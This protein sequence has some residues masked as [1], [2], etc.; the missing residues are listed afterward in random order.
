V[1]D[2]AIRIAHPRDAEAI[3]SI[4]APIVA[5][6]VVSFEERVP[7]LEDMRERIA[8]SHTWL[9]A[10]NEGNLVGYAYASRFHPRSAYRWSAEVSI[11]LASAARGRGLGRFLLDAVLHRLGAMGYVNAF[12]GIT[13][14]NDASIRLFESSGFTKIATW[15]DAGFKLGRWHDVGW[16]QLQLREPSI[17]PPQLG[18]FD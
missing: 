12:A 3:L 10:E 9:V 5:D 11:Y 2:A 14:P 8:A 4:Y 18:Q 13:L 15:K 16:W 6:T 7:S 1:K 17:P